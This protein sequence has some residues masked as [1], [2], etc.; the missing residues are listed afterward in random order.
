ML[1]PFSADRCG[2]A[3]VTVT[4][5]ARPRVFISYAR[6]DRKAAS[7]VYRD[8]VKRNVQPW[9]DLE[10]LLPG[11][12]WQEEI[13]K[14]ITGSDFFLALL[15]HHSVSKRGYIQKELRHALDVLDEFPEG[16][17]YLIPARLNECTP[18]YR[19][20]EKI[21]WVDLFPFYARGIR[22]ILD[23]LKVDAEEPWVDKSTI[24]GTE[25]DGARAR[26]AL[27]NEFQ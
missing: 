20:M 25:T 21:H 7:K 4:S 19:R 17:V 26:L 18:A 24:T 8:L 23:V 27:H 1:A 6:E 10:N 9:M 13:R 12:D 14:A 15:S 11:Q 16:H 5:T 22:R 3:E 2:V